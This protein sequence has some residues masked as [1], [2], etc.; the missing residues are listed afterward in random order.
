MPPCRSCLGYAINSATAQATDTLTLA[1]N[2]QAGLLQQ[3]NHGFLILNIQSLLKDP[4]IWSNL[5]AALM[6]KKLTFEVPSSSSIVPYH[7]PD[8]PLSVTLVL[9]GQ[10][11]HFYALQKSMRNSADCSRFRLNLKLSYRET[12]NTN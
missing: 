9:V 2:H 7:L 11:A 1:M 6:S 12:P 8:F 5:K 10:A 4:E 3:A